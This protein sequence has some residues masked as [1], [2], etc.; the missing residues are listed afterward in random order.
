[1]AG[2]L[3]TQYR[4]GPYWAMVGAAGKIELNKAALESISSTFFIH[5]NLVVFLK[6]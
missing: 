4:S 2:D 5:L 6:L 1:M 3:G